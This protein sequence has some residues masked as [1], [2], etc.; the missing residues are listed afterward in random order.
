MQKMFCLAV[1]CCLVSLGCGCQAVSEPPNNETEDM[2][3]AKWFLGTGA[4]GA[5][6]GEDGDLYLD[7]DRSTVYVKNAGA[8]VHVAELQGPQGPAGETGPQG[9]AGPSGPAGPPGPAG[10]MSVEYWTHV[11]KPSEVTYIPTLPYG[12][13][14]V[15]ILDARF[16]A[17]DWIDIWTRSA[18][19]AWFRLAPTWDNLLEVWYGIWYTYNGSIMYRSGI[20]PTGHVLVFF[21]SPTVLSGSTSKRIGDFNAAEYFWSLMEEET[22]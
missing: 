10:Q 21:R 8:W 2:L 5:D 15:N 17:N 3:A 19:G 16:G 4:P 18:D 1:A 22:D 6:I 12:Y 20:D 14:R 9:P 11:V 13:Y 7:T